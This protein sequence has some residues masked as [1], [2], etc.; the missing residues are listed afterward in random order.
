MAS[1]QLWERN[2]APAKFAGQHSTVLT[3]FQNNAFQQNDTDFIQVFVDLEC[4]GFF[5]VRVELFMWASVSYLTFQAVA[6]CLN[7]LKEVTYTLSNA[8]SVCLTKPW[9]T[10]TC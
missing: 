4:F 10:T 6:L 9:S 3:S 7:L 1:Y 5:S 2:I 8:E